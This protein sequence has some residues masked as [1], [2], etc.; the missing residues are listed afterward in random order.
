MGG[1]GPVWVHR[2]VPTPAPA[3]G[4]VLVRV[5]AMATNNADLGML[6]AADPTTGG[7]GE[8]FVAGFEYAGE[9]AAVGEGV[10]GWQVGDPVMGTAPE[11]FAEFVPVDHRFVLPRRVLEPATACALPTGLL[12]E[13]GALD[14]A[15]FQ[16][17]QSVLVTGASTGIGLIG[18]Q[19]AKALGASTIIGTT[20]SA[21]KAAVLREAG[22]D[23]VVVPP[24]ALTDTVLA[25]TG[26]EGVDI[27]LDHL[28]GPVFAQCLPATRQFGHVVNI[29]R[30]AGAPSTIDLDSLSYRNLTV[31]GVSFG[32][33]R[34]D[35]MADVIAALLPEA[36]P[37]AESGAVRP[38]IDTTVSWT[39]PARV[40]ERLGAP[41]LT[42][43]VVMTLD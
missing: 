37:A 32:F 10:T 41:D 2:E 39:E 26:G 17:G 38:V 4:Q 13:H 19:V 8:S 7:S 22:V 34:P 5:A 43:K 21:A 29:G 14:A 31:H 18:C 20:R 1:A 35:H 40:V 30:L 24:A 28:G 23:T 9:I 16:S 33:S 36:L 27:V 6:T 42:G 25:A 3:P 11:S 15:G 12:T